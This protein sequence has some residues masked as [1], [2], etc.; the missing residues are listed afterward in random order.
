MKN[1]YKRHYNKEGYIDYDNKNKEI[2]YQDVMTVTS[3]EKFCRRKNINNSNITKDLKNTFEYYGLDLNFISRRFCEDSKRDYMIPIIS[4]DILA[5]MI[6]NSR[7]NKVKNKNEENLTKDEFIQHNEKIFK[8]IE[9]LQKKKKSEIKDSET[10]KKNAEMNQ[11]LSMFTDRLN[12]FFNICISDTNVHESG[13]IIRSLI[14]LLDKFLYNRAYKEVEVEELEQEHNMYMRQ[15]EGSNYL[16]E[17]LLKEYFLKSIESNI[18]ILDFFKR[19]NITIEEIKNGLNKISNINKEYG[20]ENNDSENLKIL[21]TCLTTKIDEKEYI[22]Q[23]IL[24]LEETEENIDGKNEEINYLKNEG[25][26]ILNNINT[27]YILGKE[28]VKYENL[29]I[30]LMFSVDKEIDKNSSFYEEYC[31]RWKNSELL[32]DEFMSFMFKKYPSMKRFYLKKDWKRFVEMLM[33][34]T[35][36]ILLD[37]EIFFDEYG[38]FDIEVY[39]KYVREYKDSKNVKSREL[40]NTIE[41]IKEKIDIYLE[42]LYCLETTMEMKAIKRLELMYEDQAEKDEKRIKMRKKLSKLNERIEE[43]RDEIEKAN[44]EVKKIVNNEL[45]KKLKEKSKLEREI[46]KT[47]DLKNT[48]DLAVGKMFITSLYVDQYNLNNDTIDLE[49]YLNSL[50]KYNK[51]KK[52]Y[53]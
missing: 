41:N 19:E 16:L 30:D 36:L 13:D 21:H 51:L 17:T 2:N 42:D 43:L 35:F 9:K 1:I 45:Q 26:Y 24:K 18:E 25:R 52:F 29:F 5:L 44:K 50:G 10:Y 32:K 14:A 47:K 20:L 15:K 48:I 28:Y 23:Y 53:F 31:N 34:K 4:E 3:L 46:Y 37:E 49:K 12:L 11:L 39:F 40:K 38:E 33:K 22:G 8:L 6:E 27:G 7:N